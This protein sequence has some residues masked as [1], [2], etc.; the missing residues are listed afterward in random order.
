MSVNI[1]SLEDL[2]NLINGYKKEEFRNSIISKNEILNNY[3]NIYES[4]KENYN[5]LTLS[6]IENS[7]NRQPNKLFMIIASIIF[8][9]I[10]VMLYFGLKKNII[11]I[12]KKS[13][14]ISDKF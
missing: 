14:I 11:Q 7:I 3:K 6:N 12:L 5:F 13:K 9:N 2:A 10:I 1:N 8:L 4:S